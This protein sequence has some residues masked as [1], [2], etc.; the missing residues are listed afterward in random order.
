MIVLYHSLYTYAMRL[1]LGFRFQPFSHRRVPG[2]FIT[3]LLELGG[4]DPLG[5]PLSQH[6]SLYVLLRLFLRLIELE[7]KHCF[8]F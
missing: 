5:V 8:F 4:S 3:N 1:L 7:T 6:S 2:M